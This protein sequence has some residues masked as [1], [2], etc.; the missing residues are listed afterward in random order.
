MS[1][2][3]FSVLLCDLTPGSGKDVILLATV[4]ALTDSVLV[5]DYMPSVSVHEAVAAKTL[6]RQ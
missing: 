3:S 2:G 6:A 1:T 4:I 5:C